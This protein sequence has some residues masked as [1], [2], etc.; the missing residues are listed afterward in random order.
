MLEEVVVYVEIV[1]SETA[2]GMK[3]CVVSSI[4]VLFQ[5]DI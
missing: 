3:S 1:S 2:S 5:F 4:G